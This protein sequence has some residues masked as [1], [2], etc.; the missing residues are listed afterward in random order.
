MIE[1]TCLAGEPP[2]YVYA[3]YLSTSLPRYPVTATTSI[4][5]GGAGPT[6][7]PGFDDGLVQRDEKDDRGVFSPRRLGKA[8]D[9][10][11]G[12]DQE[13]PVEAHSP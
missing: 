11:S 7:V 12:G 1:L 5:A 3:L 9:G 6:K 4:E 8:L 2:Q 13:A 10:R